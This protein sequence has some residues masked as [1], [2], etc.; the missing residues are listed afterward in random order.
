MYNNN[1]TIS[2]NA[3]N[4]KSNIFINTPIT[5]SSLPYNNIQIP[6]PVLNKTQIQNHKKLTVK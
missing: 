1:N 6:M 3:Q 5:T 4:N 2:Q